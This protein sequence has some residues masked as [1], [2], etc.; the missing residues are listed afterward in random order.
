MS[1]DTT[2]LPVALA[3]FEVGDELLFADRREWWAVRALAADRRYVILTTIDR[4]GPA[5]FGAVLYTIIDTEEL[6]RGPLNVIGGGMGINTTEG[7][8]EHIDDTVRLLENGFEVSH[9][10]RVDLLVD[11]VRPS[12]A[13]GPVIRGDQLSAAAMQQVWHW[14]KANGC[15]W[16][17]PS[18][19]VIRIKGKHVE[20]ECY[21]VRNTRQTLT[22]WPKHFPLDWTIPTKT[23]RFRIRHP[24]NPPRSQHQAPRSEDPRP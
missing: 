9:R 20:V 22:L 24:L 19:A 15:R 11:G 2:T 16:L 18:D 10:S 7:P 21:T 14:L 12:R 5:S 4:T 6:V 23:R 1:T 8:D 3:D 13:Y 17:F